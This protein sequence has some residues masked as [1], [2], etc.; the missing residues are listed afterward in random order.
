MAKKPYIDLG[1][2]QNRPQ[3]QAAYTEMSSQGMARPDA[4]IKSQYPNIQV[5]RAGTSKSGGPMGAGMNL[6]PMQQL[7]PILII[8]IELRTDMFV[9]VESQAR[10]MRRSLTETTLLNLIKT[11]CYEPLKNIMYQEIQSL[12]PKDS[13]RLRNMLMLSIGGGATGGDSSSTSQLHSL[14]PFFVVMS[15]GNI[16][17]ASVVNQMPTPWLVHPGMHG[18]KLQTVHKKSN[19][20]STGL[21]RGQKSRKYL[22]DPAAQTNWFEKIYLS[23][24]VQAQMLWDRTKVE[25]EQFLNNLGITQNTIENPLQGMNLTMIVD[26]LFEVR[27]G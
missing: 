27:F 7:P 13:G 8:S 14:H 9:V 4:V 22:N 2:I 25:L 16:P 18:A 24:V 5:W 11:Y 6:G 1:Y 19:S 10:A 12:A 20:K 23:G 3:Y 17:Y 26:S 15:T 21:G